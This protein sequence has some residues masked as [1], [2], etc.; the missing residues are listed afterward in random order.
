MTVTGRE[1]RVTGE[2]KRWFLLVLAG[3]I[4]ILRGMKE[5]FI[6]IKPGDRNFAGPDQGARGH[7]WFRFY[8]ATGAVKDL[9]LA[10]FGAALVFVLRRAQGERK[11]AR[12]VPGLLLCG[13][14]I[15][16]GYELA[17]SVSR[18]GEMINPYSEHIVFFGSEGLRVSSL[19]MHSIRA[20]LIGGTAV[21]IGWRK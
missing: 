9:L 3:A 12:L 5:G 11:W 8:H 17:Y 6:M 1:S 19:V 20:G 21:W 2:K 15:W 14:V 18:F 4:G 13:L 10:A 7:R 16:E